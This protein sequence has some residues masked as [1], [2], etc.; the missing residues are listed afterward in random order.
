MN[1]FIF[2]ISNVGKTTVGS[3]LAA[4]LGFRVFDLD[5]VIRKKYKTTIKKF[6][7]NGTVED[8]DKLRGAAI[9]QIVNSEVGDKVIIISPMTYSKYYEPVLHADKKSICIQL[10]DTPRNI[11]NRLIFTDENDKI[12]KDDEYKKKYE[13][14]YL[15]DIQEDLNYYGKIF[16]KFSDITYNMNGKDAQTCANELYEIINKLR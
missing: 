6:I 13:L 15:N 1:I 3:M 11:F 4:K 12:Y 5:N 16:A 10:K 2:G 7:K 8:R 14:N 9:R